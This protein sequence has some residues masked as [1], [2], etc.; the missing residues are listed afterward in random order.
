M[1]RILIADDHDVVRSGLR[2]VLEAHHACEVVA[3]AVNGREAIHKA[4]ETAPDVAILD[5]S[6]PVVN[7]IEAT[8]QI[9]V[10]SP[11]TEVLKPRTPV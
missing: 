11:K 4:V 7:G 1:I 6:M 8:R 2:N 9:R 3:E 5:Y 10:R